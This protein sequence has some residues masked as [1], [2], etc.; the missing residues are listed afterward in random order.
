MCISTMA[1][2]FGVKASAG[3]LQNLTYPRTLVLLLYILSW[4][5]TSMSAVLLL[6]NDGNA[7]SCDLSVMTC[8]VFYAGSKIVIYLWLIERVWVV[9]EAKTSRLD[10]FFYKFHLLMLTPYICIF[11]LMMVFRISYIDYDGKC[12]IGLEAIASIPLLVYDFVFSSYITV[13]FLRPLFAVGRS[14]GREWSPQDYIFSL[15]ET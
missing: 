1:V 4:T 11:V 15:G 5:F 9:T 6:T 8:V 7:L 3:R 10:T 2:L 13:L 12:V 14:I